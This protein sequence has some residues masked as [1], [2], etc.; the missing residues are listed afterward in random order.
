MGFLPQKGMGYGVSGDYGLWGRFP[1]IPTR[2]SHNPMGYQGLWVTRGMGQEGVDCSSPRVIQLKSLMLHI[3][4]IACVLV[5]LHL[6]TAIGKL[7]Y[8]P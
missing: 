1:P 5:Q 3:S 7:A 6:V 4:I 8:L 2:E